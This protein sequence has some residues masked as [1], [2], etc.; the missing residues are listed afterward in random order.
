M[1]EDE[2]SQDPGTAGS[3]GGVENH[4]RLRDLVRVLAPHIRPYR[5]VLGTLAL[6]NMIPGAILGLRPLV[7]AP[8]LGVVLKSDVAPA[9]RL[10]DLTLNNVGPTLQGL[11]GEATAM[12]GGIF[13]ACALTY[14]LLTL[15]ATALMALVKTSA[16]SVRLRLYR[17][18]IASLH[19]HVFG[20]SLRFF[21]NTRTGELVSRFANDLNK[22][23]LSVDAIA[24]GAIQCTVQIAVGAAILFRTNAQ[25]TTLILL[26]GSFHFVIT[27]F[28]GGW[29]RSRTREAFGARATFNASLVEAVQSVFVIKSFAAEGYGG[30]RVTAASEELRHK[31]FRSFLCK[32]LEDPARVLTDAV[33]SALILMICHYALVNELLSLQGMVLFFYMAGQLV[34]PMSTL[35]RLMVRLKGLQGAGSRVVSVFSLQPQIPDGPQSA[36]AFQNALTFDSVHFSHGD[37]PVLADVS[38]SVK[39]GE[40]I[41]I[42]GP[43]GSGKTTMLNMVLRLYDPDAGTVSLDGT[44]VRTFTRSSYRSLFGVVPQ[45]AFLFND[46][47]R[48]NILL[49]RPLDQDRLAHACEVAN[50]A[51]MLSEMKAGLDT[52]VGD[53]GERLSGG[54]RQ[55]I[56]LA[57]AVYGNPDILILDEATS[58]LDAQSEVAI[59]N[60]MD[61]A[62]QGM[63]GIVVAHRLATIVNAD[64]IAVLDAGRIHAVG[65]HHELLKTNDLYKHLYELQFNTAADAA[66]DTD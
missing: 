29:V 37:Q 39:K 52:T 17:D 19:N 11:L 35:G 24:I 58:A 43:S 62:L 7:L 1:K 44:D 63:T 45:D 60:A 20:L 23:A 16:M 10:A 22:V 51:D 6:I 46:T 9:E 33:L 34:L 54:E 49:G 12:P 42:V 13:A 38:L 26:I 55:R 31:V 57:R 56:A 32:Y 50:L 2:S 18:M 48:E 64:R 25:L 14:V 3:T 30:K 15:L 4:G 66:V 8:A 5:L 59:Q 65:H 47:I 28:F 61:T 53:R 27:H 40:T 36:V 21:R 41:A